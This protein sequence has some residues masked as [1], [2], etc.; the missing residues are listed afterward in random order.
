[1]YT[2]QLSPPGGQRKQGHAAPVTTQY[3]WTLRQSAC[4]TDG[5]PIR[6]KDR[7]AEGQRHTRGASINSHHILIAPSFLRLQF[8]QILYVDNSAELESTR[9]QGD[10]Q[11][12]SGQCKDIHVTCWSLVTVYDLRLPTTCWLGGTSGECRP[13]C[14]A[15]E[16][17]WEMARCLIETKT[18]W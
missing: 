1:M 18:S 16:G 15:P 7:P 3:S 11:Q 10:E 14:S 8:L 6:Q 4:M 12:S 13:H 5:Q 2:T 17:S 9:L